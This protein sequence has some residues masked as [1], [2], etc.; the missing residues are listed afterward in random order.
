MERKAKMSST[1]S[2]LVSNA[3]LVLWAA[4]LLIFLGLSLLPAASVCLG[5]LLFSLALRLWGRLSIRQ[6]SLSVSCSV[7]HVFP[8][9]E[10]SLTY[11]LTNDKFLPLL[12]LELTQNGPEDRALSPDPAFEAYHEPGTPV[13]APRALRRTFS[14]VGS[15]QSLTVSGVWKANHRGIYRIR[16][17]SA[18]CGDGFGLVQREQN[19]PT[20]EM[21]V[22][23]VYPRLVEVDLSPFLQT[24]W[25]CDSGRNGFM[26]DHT[27]LRG[28]REYMPGDSWKSINWRMA[29]REQGLP[30]NL[31]QTILPR[32]HRFIL[33]GES[34][35]DAP[36]ELEKVLEVL[37]S[38]LV[39]LS[40]RRMDLSLC[41]PRSRRFEARTLFS[42]GSGDITDLLFHLAA[43]ECAAVPDPEAP[44]EAGRH[45]Y[46]ASAFPSDAG[47]TDARLWIFTRS[48]LSLPSELLCRLRPGQ[49][50]LV[51]ESD[52]EAP[53]QS[54][55]SALSLDRL[56]KG[57]ESA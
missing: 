21:P 54:G 5:F 31:Y 32:S 1:T 17:L 14:L 22:L 44:E 50:V 30:V 26:E 4:G 13:D 23:A 39:G 37:S 18:R 43:Y 29:A 48:G 25:N 46:L 34:F 27:V 42:G 2:I 16:R 19:L 57:G 8:G 28:S 11:T 36:Q 56:R 33:D 53:A 45:V 35:C 9:Q 7:P 51:C 49:F 38:L 12:W 52:W 41:L 6:V 10:I 3:A 55:L 20:G 40:S 15:Y 47:Q 24:Q